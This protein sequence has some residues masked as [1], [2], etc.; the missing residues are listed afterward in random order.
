MIEVNYDNTM[1][2]ARY[3]ST[4]QL[5]YLKYRV[6]EIMENKAFVPENMTPERW[7]TRINPYTVDSLFPAAGIVFLP[8]NLVIKRN[9]AIGKYIA[10]LS[11]AISGEKKWP[12][13]L[14]P[15][16]FL[17][18]LRRTMSSAIF[19]VEFLFTYSEHTW[20]AKKYSGN[21]VEIR[22]KPILLAKVERSVSSAEVKENEYDHT[23][24]ASKAYLEGIGKEFGWTLIEQPHVKT[25]PIRAKVIFQA[26]F[27]T[28]LPYNV[29]QFFSEANG[30]YT[31]GLLRACTAMIRAGIEASVTRKLSELGYESELHD[32]N[33]EPTKL[34]KKLVTISNIKG[35][36][37]NTE[38]VEGL[39]WMANKALHDPN[40]KIEPENVNSEVMKV[41]VFIDALMALSGEKDGSS[42]KSSGQA[43]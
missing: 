18:L 17:S 26:D 9:T 16:E 36:K 1:V 15:E 19:S 13:G 25:Q 33:G 8:I 39:R 24:S 3:F 40:I 27:I 37:K 14:T 32:Q 43:R 30:C 28:R 41:R 35:M 4:E 7:T 2:L 38:A 21:D 10:A 42:S 31:N 20:N 5:S 12:K 22:I 29:G 34:S 11:S 6:L 23:I